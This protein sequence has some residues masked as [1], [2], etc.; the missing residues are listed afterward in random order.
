MKKEDIP[1]SMILFDELGLAEKSQSN[2]LKV[3]HTK[4]DYASIEKGVSFIGI[5]N[6]SLDAAKLNRALYLSVPNLDNQL[7]QLQ[8]TCLSIAENISQNRSEEHTSELQSR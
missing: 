7:E 6:Y 1:L 4:F 5:S 3:L 2:P 8:K